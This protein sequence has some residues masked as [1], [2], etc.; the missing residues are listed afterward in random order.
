MEFSVK[1]RTF[2]DVAYMCGRQA[3]NTSQIFL[4]YLPDIIRYPRKPIVGPSNRDERA[5]RTRKVSNT[6]M[7][8][9]GSHLYK[10]SR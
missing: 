4:I 5:S 2:V 8:Q 7:Q 1:C 6:D 9:I 10:P 3:E